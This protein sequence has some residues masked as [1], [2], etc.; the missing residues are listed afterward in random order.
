[1]TARGIILAIWVLVA[2]AAG[3]AAAIYYNALVGACVLI[4]LLP[5]RFDP[6]IRL[7]ERQLGRV[8]VNPTTD[9]QRPPPV[10]GDDL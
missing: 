6:A 3:S 2:V 4:V 5:P 9:R 8:G 1:M 10:E 7:K